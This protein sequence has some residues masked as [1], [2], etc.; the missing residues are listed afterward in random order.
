VKPGSAR[1]TAAILATA[2]STVA[3]CANDGHSRTPAGPSATQS[4]APAPDPQRIEDLVPLTTAQAA[5]A[6]D[7]IALVV[8]RGSQVV[9]GAPGTP[10]TRTRFAVQDVLKGELPRQFAVQTI[11]GR[12]GDTVV[13]SPVQAFVRSRRY[14]LFLGPDGPAGP[15]IFPQAVLEVKQGS[16]L[17]DMLGSIRRYLR[18]R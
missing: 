15:T 5:R 6:A 17:G 3:G 16:H 8:S 12:L 4:S 7:R 13:S 1:L 10:F 9:E 14:V 2:A 18:T 11:G